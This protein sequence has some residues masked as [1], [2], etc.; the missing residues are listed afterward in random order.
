MDPGLTFA[1]LLALAFAA[2]NG[3]HDASNAIATLVATRAARPLQAIILAAIFN[4]LGPLLVGAA[5]ADTIGGIVTVAPSAAVEVIGSG[6]AG[7]V[8]WNLITWRFGLPSSSGH[9]L[10]GGLVGAALVEGGLGAVEWGGLDG[11]HPVGVLGTL[12]ALA[13]SPPLGALG[14]LVVI[15]AIRRLARRATRRWRGPVRGGEWVMSA[16]LA[17][18]HGANDAQKSVGVVAALLLAEGRIDTLAAPEWATVACAAALTV[19]TALGGWRIIR[20]VGR[21]IYR[22]Q[23]AEGLASQTSSASVIL[24]ASLLGAPTST[25]Q[26]VA[27]SVVGIGVGRRRLHHVHWLIVR[28]MGLAWLITIPATGALAIAILMLWRGLG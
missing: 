24:G 19:G 18:G 20:T 7:A 21:R 2:T 15:R 26:V 22:I 17:F 14:A 13:I 16:A 9:A 11:W 4:L 12:I 6:L 25:T 5:V 8:A 27:S 1:V 28:R 3:L 23:P 10:V